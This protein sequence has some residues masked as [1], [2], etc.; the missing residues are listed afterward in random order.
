MTAKQKP[1]GRLA[2]R[3]LGAADAAALLDAI[4]ASREAL[5]RRFRW[6]AAVISPE[7][8]AEYV[9]RTIAREAEGKEI[10]RGAFSLKS[11]ELIGVG[12]LQRL[13]EN[14]GVAELSLWVRDDRTGKG[15]AKDLGQALIELAFKGRVHRLYVRLDPANRNA[16]QVIKRLGFKY[17]GLLRREKKLNGRWIDQE[18]WG[19]LKED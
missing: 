14:P 17:E 3:P 7:Q 8:C 6:P 11:G 1:K 5:K 16:R 12:A 19:R 15:Y 18:C 13:D 10:V 4:E 9:S 2:L